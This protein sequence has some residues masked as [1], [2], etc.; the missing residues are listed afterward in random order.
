[1]AD[2]AEALKNLV[3]LDKKL[4]KNEGPTRKAVEL[5]TKNVKQAMANE[6]EDEIQLA[7]DDVEDAKVKVDQCLHACQQLH[8]YT[9]EL[10][11]D[12][13]FLVK[14]RAVVVK[15]VQHFGTV[16]KEMA[17]HAQALRKLEEDA[18]K[19]ET[20]AAKGAADVESD[21]GALNNFATWLDAALKD[22]ATN[23]PKVDKD[24]RGDPASKAAE[25][26]RL[27]LIKLNEGVTET[28]RDTK[29]AL[30][31]FQKEHADVE[32]DV[33]RELQRV[34]DLVTR[35]EDAAKDGTELLR[36]LLQL[37]QQKAAAKKPAPKPIV[38][39]EADVKKLVAPIVGI[40]PKDAKAVGE[41]AKLLK[42][43]P[44]DGWIAPL[45]KLATKYK[46]ANTNGR[47]MAEQI[48]KL[49]VVKKQ[50]AAP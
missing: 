21:L 22:Y 34:T 36:E 5:A 32:P 19:A 25:Q 7:Q 30:Q 29:K 28:L 31:D 8:E 38:V 45:G 20:A 18:R 44:P 26:A 47:A 49:P 9:N 4:A 43:S 40:D 1:M 35:G 27:K 37:K 50:L 17:K 12:R 15:V 24:A 41:L 14:N 3:D 39:S 48:V 46:S 16:Q 11:K 10:Q 2:L 13:E 42:D 23:R 33:K 6:N